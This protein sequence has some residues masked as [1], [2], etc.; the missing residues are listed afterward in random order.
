MPTR[1]TPPQPTAFRLPLRTQWLA[2]AALVAM[3][4]TGGT[5][6]IAHTPAPSAAVTSAPYLGPIDLEVDATDLDRRIFRVRQRVPVKPGALKLLFPQWLPGEHAPNGHVSRLAGLVIETDAGQQLPW[7]RDTV[8]THAF[9]VTVPNN[10]KALTLRY[11]NLT[12][13]KNDVGRI[14]VTPQMLNLQWQA[15]VLYPAGHAYSAITIQPKLK[16]PSGWQAATALRPTAATVS[17]PSGDTIS[18]APVTLEHLVDSPVFAGQ[19]VKRIALDEANHPNP[20]VLNLVGDKPDDIE[21]TPEQ[22]QAHKN[23]VVQADKLFG[24]RHYQHYDFLLAVSEELSG[25]GLE[26]HQS[27]ENGVRPG[28]FKNW[29]KSTRARGL[30]PHEYT[31]SWNGKYRRPAD[32]TT[33]HYNTPMQTSLL[34]LYEGQTQF[35]GRVLTTRSQLETLPQGLQNLALTAATYRDRAGRQWRSLQ[36]TTQEGPMQGRREHKDWNDWQRD[37]DYYDEATLMYLELEAL[38]RGRTN[39]QKGLDDF[40]RAFFGGPESTRGQL[41]PLTY[42]FDDIV[43]TLNRI[44]PGDWAAHLRQRLDGVGQ[45]ALDVDKAL[46]TVG[47]KLVYKADESVQARDEAMGRYRLNFAH[48]LGLVLNPTGEVQSVAWESPAYHA[49]ILRGQQLLAVNGMAFT[50]EGLHQA[51]KDNTNGKKP[52]ELIFKSDKHYRVVKL[53]YRGGPRHPV[54]ERIDGQTDWLTPLL[55]PR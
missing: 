19:H 10:V 30:L 31:H 35:W 17:G 47:W 13:L 32:L 53:D 38:L 48:S 11:Q 3:T 5:A 8:E 49:A 40:A 55:S 16:L 27:S 51:L 45:Q 29:D 25:I 12:P 44:A 50:Q 33:P 7:A 26:H 43:A 23:L 2:Q 34:W 15:T 9:H 24:V 41:G 1:T 22:I 4:T 18:Y 21:P 36:D 37:A 28:Y 20:V 42:T 39:G 6:A 54:L 52:I 14:V 46:A